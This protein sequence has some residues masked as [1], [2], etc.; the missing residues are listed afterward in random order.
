M[1]LIL[2]SPRSGTTLLRATLNQHPAILVPDE[3]D[4]IVPACMICDRIGDE[5]V[6]RAMVADLVVGSDRYAYSIAPYLGPDDVRTV[7]SGA[8]Y[9][10]LAMVEALYDAIAGRHGKALAGDKSPNDLSFVSELLRGG[11]LGRPIKVIHLVRDVRDVILS[12]SKTL[13]RPPFVDTA[14]PL[15]WSRENLSLFRSMHDLPDRYL[16]VRFDDMVL[17][18]EATFR[19]VAAF[20]GVRFHPDMLS[21]ETRGMDKVGEDHHRN[22]NKP[23]LASRVAVW[24]REM[25]PE[26]SHAIAS[27]SREA[28]C[29][30]GWGKPEAAPAAAGA[31]GEPSAAAHEHEREQGMLRLQLELDDQRRWARA[32]A[33]EISKRDRII[34]DLRRALNEQTEWARASAAEVVRRDSIITELQ[35]KLEEQTLWARESA[36]A[37]AKRDAIVA[38]LQRTARASDGLSRACAV[39]AT[40]QERL[41]AELSG[42]LDEARRDPPEARRPGDEHRRWTIDFPDWVWGVLRSP[43]AGQPRIE[44]VH[45]PRTEAGHRFNVQQDG[46]AHLAVEGAGFGTAAVLVIAGRPLE[47][48]H[49]SDRLLSACVPDELFA[50]PGVLPIWVDNCGGAHPSAIHCLRVLSER[51]VAA[52]RPASGRGRRV[53][54]ALN[55]LVRLASVASWRSRLPLLRLERHLAESRKRREASARR[56][57]APSTV[58][59]EA[60]GRATGQTVTTDHR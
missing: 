35:T 31:G 51:T 5:A 41:I 25:A 16:L 53:K 46:R 38:D 33:R 30:F 47:T 58:P 36:A 28:L 8:P 21:H 43:K 18:A 40:E 50:R 55:R 24:R 23:M 57:R 34:A 19:G 13:F 11:L 49:A 12:M 56:R 48:Y 45:P 54:N 6:G 4:F 1:F 59:P 42:R 2:G 27:R 60:A 20:L 44:T 29:Q 37:V 14:F 7:V 10:G 3:T 22:L 52:Y 17:D 32:G 26:R 39:R 9:S 15:D